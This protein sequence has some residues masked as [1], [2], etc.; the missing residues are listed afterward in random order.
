MVVIVTKFWGY[1]IMI[2]F[3]MIGISILVFVFRKKCSRYII[4]SQNKTWGFRFGEK[5]IKQTEYMLI[6]WAI[7][8]VIMGLLPLL[9]VGKERL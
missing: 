5:S 3:V 4:Y 6:V 9:G 7:A 8:G 2:H 1:L